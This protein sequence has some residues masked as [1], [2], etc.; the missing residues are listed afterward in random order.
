MRGTR[1]M[2]FAGVLAVT[3]ATAALAGCEDATGS[4]DDHE[5]AFGMVITNQNNVALAS[6][7][8]QRQVTGTLTVQA[9][10]D[11]HL[12]VYFLDEDGARFEV[13]DDDGEELRWTVA[14][15]AVAEIAAHDGHHDLEGKAAG[16]TTVVFQIWHG[17]HSD[18]DS[19][20]IPIT[21][22]P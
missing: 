5:E 12:R 3:L 22:T 16:N 4:D 17:S 20:A 14:N 19:P 15:T 6:V 9:G 10:A 13:D 11:Q 1:T 18:Y 7:N 21:V 2:R 8:A